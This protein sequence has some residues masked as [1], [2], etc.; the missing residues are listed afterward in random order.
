MWA[1]IWNV[2][3]SRDLQ[4]WYGS[5]L[6]L[7]Y[8][9]WAAELSHWLLYIIVRVNL[10]HCWIWIYRIYEPIYGVIS[11]QLLFNMLVWGSLKLGSMMSSW[12]WVCISMDWLCDH[13]VQLPAVV[14][15]VGLH[16]TVLP[17][18]PPWQEADVSCASLCSSLARG[19]C[20]MCFPVFFP[21]RRQM[22]AVGAADVCWCEADQF[23][24]GFSSAMERCL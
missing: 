5:S 17:C 19:R 11:G 12:N 4:Y 15:R 1:A 21:G 13:R 18:V 2:H 24:G 23:H 7:Q 22:W 3:F 16:W 14:D 10:S 20:E 9:F 6:V 8:K